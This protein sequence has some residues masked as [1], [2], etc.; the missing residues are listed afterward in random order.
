MGEVVGGREADDAGAE[1]D[2]LRR[3]CGHCAAGRAGSWICGWEEDGRCIGQ[4]A[5]GLCKRARGIVVR[6]LQLSRY[7]TI[8][9]SGGRCERRQTP[10]PMTSARPIVLHPSHPRGAC[11]V[12]YPAP[13]DPQQASPQKSGSAGTV[14]SFFRALPSQG[15]AGS[16]FFVLP[17]PPALPAPL[18]NS[19][20]QAA[21]PPPKH[22]R[23]TTQCLPREKSS[24]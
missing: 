11:P 10:Q 3:G 4:L 9:P 2:G 5:V 18:P 14:L 22:F 16:L 7:H 17:C 12:P 8:S 6:L 15:G 20:P 19:S 24:L 23:R 21:S 1:D 13:G